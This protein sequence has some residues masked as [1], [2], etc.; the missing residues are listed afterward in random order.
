MSIT[1]IADARAWLKTE[2]AD[3]ANLQ[4]ALDSAEDHVSKITGITVS[5][6]SPPTKQLKLAIFALA[7]HWLEN[8]REAG[9]PLEIREVPLGVRNILTQAQGCNV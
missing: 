7:G 3:D 6:A 2:A 8:M 5:Q 1:L 4:L 9:G